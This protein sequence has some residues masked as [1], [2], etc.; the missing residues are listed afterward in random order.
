MVHILRATF[1]IE[2]A[3]KSRLVGARCLKHSQ[4]ENSLTVPKLTNLV[5]CF[6]LVTPAIFENFKETI[7]SKLLPT[8]PERFLDYASIT[9]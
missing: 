5:N 3:G 2:N 7:L 4:P 6:F 9:Y 1:L 8:V